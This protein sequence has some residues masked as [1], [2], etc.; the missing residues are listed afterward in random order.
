[1]GRAYD[2]LYLR[3]S[4]KK[5]KRGIYKMDKIRERKMRD[6]SQ[7]KCIKDRLDK[8]LVKEGEIKHGQ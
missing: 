1:M 8:F 4:T 3:L 5:G 6:F 2:D 7:V